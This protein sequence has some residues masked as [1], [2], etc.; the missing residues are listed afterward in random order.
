[1]RSISPHHDITGLPAQP[2]VD[3]IGIWS[4]HWLGTVLCEAEADFASHYC[5]RCCVGVLWREN[6]TWR[7]QYEKVHGSVHGFQR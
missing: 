4:R 6:P 3:L 7:T 5:R 2:D 1:M